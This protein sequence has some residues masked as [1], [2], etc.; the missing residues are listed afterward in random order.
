MSTLV[1][2]VAVW[3]SSRLKPGSIRRASVIDGWRAKR[4]EI[5]RRSE[6]RAV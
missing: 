2:D 3:R 1:T 6:G 5:E 4:P